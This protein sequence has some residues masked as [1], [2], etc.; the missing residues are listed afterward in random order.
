MQPD[1]HAL[2]LAFDTDDAEFARGVEVGR[3][4]ERLTNSPGDEVEEMIHTSNAEMAMRIGEA[5]G[6]DVVSAEH[7]DTWM[8]VTFAAQGAP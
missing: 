4:W 5:L 3:L 6:R 8:T 1:G 2:A 7:D